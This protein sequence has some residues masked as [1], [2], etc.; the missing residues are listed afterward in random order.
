[1]R[2]APWIGW[3]WAK[4]RR[5]W[6]QHRR[7]NPRTPLPAVAAKRTGMDAWTI[8]GLEDD[9]KADEAPVHVVSKVP[10]RKVVDHA[11]EQLFP[12]SGKPRP[13]LI[14]MDVLMPGT[15]NGFQA[16]RR[17]T[18]DPGTASIPII[19]MSTKAEAP[20]QVWGIK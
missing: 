17:L 1:M 14:L 7:E 8:D 12:G 6:P 20:D 18:R 10:P 11:P 5:P 15:N 16:T 4:P 19:M 13:D 2:T 9:K 3:T